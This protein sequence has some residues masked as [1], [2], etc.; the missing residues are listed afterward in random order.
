VTLDANVQ[1]PLAMY[2]TQRSLGDIATSNPAATRVFLRHK[3]DFCCGGRRS[4]GEACRAA[5]LDPEAI[6]AELEREAA[7]DTALPRADLRSQS[8]LADHIESRYHATLRRDLPTLIEA[9]RKV[10]RVHAQKPNV[11]AGLAD[12]LA[13]FFDD[14]QQ[15]MAKEEKILFPMIRRGAAGHMVAMPITVMEREHDTHG[16]YL[17]EIRKLTDDLRAPAHA[18]ATWRALYDGLGTLEADLV[19]HI[20]LENNVLFA[21]ATRG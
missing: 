5:G 6:V 21:R 9:A 14:M 15:H 11:P 3:L 13:A 2:T 12:V 7:P 4:L 10:E 8:E 18:C 20:H 1:E 19:Q 17:A 16:V